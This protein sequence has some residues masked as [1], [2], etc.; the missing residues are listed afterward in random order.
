MPATLGSIHAKISRCDA[1]AWDDVVRASRSGILM[2][3]GC[4]AAV[5][6]AC[7]GQARFARHRLRRWACRGLL[8]AEGFQEQAHFD[9]IVA[10]AQEIV[11]RAL[12]VTDPGSRQ[13]GGRL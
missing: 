4:V 12:N 13:A 11:S 8:D 5:E 7:A 3:R 10:E 6:D 9:A 1:D 2:S